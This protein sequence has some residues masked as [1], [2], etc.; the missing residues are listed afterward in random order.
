MTLLHKYIYFYV[1]ELKFFQFRYYILKVS[2]LAGIIQLH[3]A[4][5]SNPEI[6]KLLKAPLSTVCDTVILYKSEKWMTPNYTYT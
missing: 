5:K 3:C 2:L 4:G 1:S 6:V